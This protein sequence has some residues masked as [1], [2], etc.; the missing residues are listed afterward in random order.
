MMDIF[1]SSP[2]VSW[3]LAPSW[4][5]QI[6]AL[7]ESPAV[8]AASSRRSRT[9]MNTYIRSTTGFDVRS[10]PG[11]SP[12]VHRP[13]RTGEK[14]GEHRR[15]HYRRSIQVINFPTLHKIHTFIIHS[16]SHVFLPGCCSGPLATDRYVASELNCVS[17]VPGPVETYRF[18]VKMV[19]RG[20]D[21][22][23][24]MDIFVVSGCSKEKYLFK[25]HA[26]SS[27]CH[28]TATNYEAV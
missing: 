8:A 4:P 3:D 18:P 20:C 1:P 25:G 11:S 22:D 2:I 13:D 15:H 7:Q 19:S 21:S 28:S 6:I 12:A 23:Q 14:T 10:F 27:P 24:I 26:W 9:F 17:F 5:V 16:P